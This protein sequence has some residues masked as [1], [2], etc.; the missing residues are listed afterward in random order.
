MYK[1][2]DECENC[3]ACLIPSIAEDANTTMELL[4][5]EVVFLRCF[6]VGAFLT[7][8][9]FIVNG[10]TTLSHEFNKYVTTSNY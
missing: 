8:R 2:K 10:H 4:F 6:P 5:I 9:A 7:D 3:D 1:V